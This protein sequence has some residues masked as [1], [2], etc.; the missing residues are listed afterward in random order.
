MTK[1]DQM[2]DEEETNTEEHYHL[3]P[4]SNRHQ[5]KEKNGSS[6]RK[7]GVL[8]IAGAVVAVAAAAI[9]IFWPTST[10]VNQKAPGEQTSVPQATSTLGQE[11]SQPREVEQEPVDNQPSQ[12]SDPT[13]KQKAGGE[14]NSG[15]SHDSNI[16]NQ[17][18]PTVPSS[19][20]NSETGNGTTSNSNHAQLEQTQPVKTEQKVK[21][22]LYRVQKGDNLYKISRK[23]YGNNDGAKRIAHFNGLK[24]E[25]SLPVGRKLYIPITP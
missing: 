1:H 25:A 10:E 12:S 20:T 3:P 22:K 2:K 5:K 15:T 24:M 14:S 11:A 13:V 9:W 17:T 7:I 18:T 19:N 4:R 8:P 6:N 16:Q 23:Y 21:S